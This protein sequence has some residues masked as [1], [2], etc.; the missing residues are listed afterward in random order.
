MERTATRYVTLYRTNFRSGPQGRVAAH[1]PVVSFAVTKRGASLVDGERSEMLD[2]LEVPVVDPR[3]R[4][5]VTFHENPVRWADLVPIAYRAG[6]YFVRVVH[7]IQRKDLAEHV[8]KTANEGAGWSHYPDRATQRRL[9]EILASLRMSQVIMAVAGGATTV[10]SA[11]RRS[12]IRDVAGF[13]RGLLDATR[14]GYVV[15]RESGKGSSLRLSP[16]GKAKAA[17]ITQL[18]KEHAI[19]LQKYGASGTVLG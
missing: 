14:N 5:S 11:Y 13:A 2:M 12:A 15:S 3:T 4:A 9:D 18:R 7:G 10:G 17:Q 8:R 16:A 19:W 1:E 6:D